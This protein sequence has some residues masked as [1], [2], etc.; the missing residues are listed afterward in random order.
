[1]RL[2]EAYQGMQAANLSNLKADISQGVADIAAGR[3]RELDLN[4]IKQRGRATR[5]ARQPA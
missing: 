2:F 1:L 4:E 3:V 5:T